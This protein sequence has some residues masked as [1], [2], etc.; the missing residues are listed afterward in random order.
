M[1]TVI[2][3]DGSF[4][5][6]RYGAGVTFSKGE[7]E[8]SFSGTCSSSV[9]AELLSIQFGMYAALDRGLADIVLLNDCAPAVERTK[10]ILEYGIVA[11]TSEAETAIA[12]MAFEFTSCEVEF[13]S[14]KYNP[15]HTLSRVYLEE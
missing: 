14:T 10:L 7:I 9:E 6:G 15:A 12:S 1:T 2:F 13:S 3:T 4:K 5:D 11:A 8:L